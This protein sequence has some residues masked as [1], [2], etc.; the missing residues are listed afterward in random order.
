MA[1]CCRF[2]IFNSIWT[3][4]E[5]GPCPAPRRRGVA[6][7]HPW[8]PA[9]HPSNGQVLRTVGCSGS[10]K[11]ATKSGRCAGPAAIEKRTVAPPVLFFLP[12]RSCESWL[13]R[14]RGSDHDCRRSK[15]AAEGGYNALQSP[16]P[17]LYAAVETGEQP[18][19]RLPLHFNG[20][21]PN[22]SRGDQ[23]EPR[24]APTEVLPEP[25]FSWVEIERL[26]RRIS[27]PSAI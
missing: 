20:S 15:R 6:G 18:H 7:R 22:D 12:F 24:G 3:R 21:V 27:A 13:T 25:E 14:R 8:P 26:T 19:P 9:V 16:F 4:L 17:V 5:Q 11:R 10:L 2:S 1:R 23:S